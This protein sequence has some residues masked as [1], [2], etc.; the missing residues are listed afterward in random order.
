VIVAGNLPPCWKKDGVS[1][2][3]NIGAPAYNGFFGA[4]HRGGR[5]AAA[6]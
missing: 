4:L 1:G 2:E 6:R 5:A 3:G